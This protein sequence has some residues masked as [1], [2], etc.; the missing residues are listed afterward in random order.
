VNQVRFHLGE[1]AAA[2]HDGDHRAMTRL[3]QRMAESALGVIAVYTFAAWV[4]VALCALVHPE[5]LRLPLTHLFAWPHEDTFGV[6]CFAISF[7]SALGWR[8]LR[9]RRTLFSSGSARG[10]DK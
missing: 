8:M 2:R 4:Y 5:T 9:A 1:M 3:N 7:V 10:S 6:M